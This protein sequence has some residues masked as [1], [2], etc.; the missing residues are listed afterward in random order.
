MMANDDQT[1]SSDTPAATHRVA[2]LLRTLLQ[3]KVGLPFLLLLAF[4]V[5]LPNLNGPLLGWHS[6][7]Q[8]DTASMARYFFRSSE[9]VGSPQVAWSGAGP[10]YVE[11]ELP[12]YS[13]ALGLLYRVTG[14][15]TATGRLFSIVL[16]LLGI[17]VFFLLVR[18]ISG[19]RLAL[20]AAAL[21]ALLP[22]NVFY[23]RV[24][25]PEPLMLL[26]LLCG[27]HFFRLFLES[28]RIHHW[29]G[30][31][32]GIT[33]AAGIKPQ[34]LTLGLVFAFLAWRSP[35]KR[36]FL[37]W[38]L[39][40]FAVSVVGAVAAWFY[41]AHRLFEAT[42]LT[43]GIW[44]YGADKWGNWQLLA[45]W[46]FWQDILLKSLGE[47]YLAVLGLP[48][49]LYTL[50]RRPRKGEE[51]LFD[52]WLVSGSIALVVTA[53]GNLIHEYYQ[54]PL[55]VP[56]CYYLALAVDRLLRP[57]S[58]TW[59]KAVTVA[60]LVGMAAVGIYRYSSYLDKEDP[61][62]SHEVA[63]ASA[64]RQVTEPDELVVVVN[65]GDPTSLYLAD[66]RGWILRPSQLSTE[67]LRDLGAQ[68][69]RVLGVE[70]RDVPEDRVQWIVE[71]TEPV[72]VA[73][74]PGTVVRRF[75]SHQGP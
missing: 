66:R 44:G 67:L 54:L 51:K 48:L 37:R 24:V 63:L 65:R 35:G 16:S 23:S 32:L 28:G 36:A 4:A 17:L 9:G 15:H 74:G 6:W 53:R 29:I 55:M 21:Y 68:G 25:M 60:A 49:V 34:S 18:E 31:W 12:I 19:P 42:G 2:G 39:W 41:H 22:L 1:P 33:V 70:T 38:D 46:D 71:V 45:T 50:I 59:A 75:P 62:T 14:E 57:E 52:W 5:R 69:A 40:L 13:Y 26:G 10:G 30:S 64:L 61:A 58:K 56:L 47:R 8:A 72:E 3:P 7:R 11:S 43:F 73:P 20:L 27:V